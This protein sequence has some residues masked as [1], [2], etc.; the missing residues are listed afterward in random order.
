[1]RKEIHKNFIKIK[2]AEL[3]IDKET[4]KKYKE[5]YNDC[6]TYQI[7]LEEWKFYREYI[8]LD[9]MEDNQIDNPFLRRKAEELNLEIFKIDGDEHEYIHESI[10]YAINKY[11]EMINHIIKKAYF[12][13]IKEEQE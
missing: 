5:Q 8:G 9:S 7:N 12:K 4:K 11:P 10:Q 6:A 2:T 1:M 3:N 13:K